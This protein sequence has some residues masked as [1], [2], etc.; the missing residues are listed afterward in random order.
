MIYCSHDEEAQ[1]KL[2]LNL[3]TQ[4]AEMTGSLWIQ[5]QP[6]LHSEFQDPQSYMAKTCL[7]TNKQQNKQC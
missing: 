6:G 7:G 3:S 4:E 2:G 1:S 5:G